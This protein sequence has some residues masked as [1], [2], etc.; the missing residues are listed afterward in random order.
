MDEREA[1]TKGPEGEGATADERPSADAAGGMRQLLAARRERLERLRAA[2]VDPFPPRAERTHMA[3]EAVAAFEAVEAEGGEEGPEGVAVAGRLVGAL[4]KMGGSIFVHLRDESGELQLH[5]RKNRLGP[6][7]FARVAE[8]VDAGDIVGAEGTMFRTRKGE[9]SLAVDRLE[10]LAKSLRPLPD[11][12]HGLQ[13]PET[14]L[15]QR[16]LDLLSSEESRAAFRLRSLILR[17]M[18]RFLDQRGFLEVETPVLQPIYGGGAARPF[19]THYH[20]LDQ[21]M[22]LRIADELYLKRLLVGGFERVYEIAKDFRNEGIDRTHMPEFTMMEVY[23]AYADY[24]DMMTLTEEMIAAIARDCLGGTTVEIDG[25]PLDLAPPWRRATVRDAILEGT[26]IDIEACP[27]LASLEAAVAAA[28]HEVAKQPTWPR[29]VDE[30]LGDFV[31]PRIWEPTFLMDH[32]VALSPLAKRKPED[33][34]YAERFEP[35]VAGFELGNAFSELNDP[36]EQRARFEDMAA[37]R[38]AGDDEAH[39]LDEDFLEALLYGM[40]PTGGLGIG[41]DRLVMVLTGRMNIRDVVL[42]PQLR[43]RPDAT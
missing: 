8:D 4:R 18:R 29:L 40:P 31:E 35:L 33:P 1:A 15:R 32:P 26:G 10:V 12:W 2:G 7:A 3:A 13:D 19:S 22:Y 37:Q 6:E 16:Y 21:D 36:L 5:L 28:G 20:A 30:L 17:S 41:V 9:I 25:R 38:A 11:K 27:D 34:R 14:R 39:P 24:R 23:W 43:H 42:F